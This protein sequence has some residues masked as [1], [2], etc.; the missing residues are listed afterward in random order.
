MKTYKI[1]RFYREDKPARTIRRGLTLEEAQLHC[2]DPRT[3]KENRRGEVI[4]FDGYEEE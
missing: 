1:M 2:R 4:W 3:R